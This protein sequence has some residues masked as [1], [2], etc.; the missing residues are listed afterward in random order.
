MQSEWLDIR[1]VKFCRRWLWVVGFICAAGAM[2]RGGGP[3][4]IVNG[5]AARWPATVP[6]GLVLDNGPLG[7]LSS[8]QAA[9]L[10]GRAVDAWNQVPGS[11]ITFRVDGF[12]PGGL[13]VTDQNLPNPRSFPG[14]SP[15]IYD[16][17]GQ[18][19]EM[20]FGEG[21]SRGVGGFAGPTLVDVSSRRVISGRAV[22]NGLFAGQMEIFPRIVIHELGHVLGLGHTQAAMSM[23]ELRL[24]T[25]PIMYPVATAGSPEIPQADDIAWLSWLYPTNAFQ[26]QT[27]T[28]QGRVLRRVDIPFQGANV[29]AVK[30]VP[31]ESNSL[32][33]SESEFVSAV[34]D[35]SGGNTGRFVIP[36]LNPGD[37]VVRIEP[38]RFA[39]GRGGIGPVSN[40]FTDFPEDYFN[41][42]RESG[43]ASD[44]PAER[45]PLAV[46]AG[47]ILPLA[48]LISNDRSGD[49]LDF[50]RDDDSKIYVFPEGFR[51]P[52]GDRVFH[53]VSIN[54]DGNLTLGATDSASTPRNSSRFLGG[55]SRIAP[56]FADLDPSR[57]GHITA[58]AETG[59]VTFTWSGVPRF[60]G[61]AEECNTF[62]VTL[63]ENG[64]ILFRYD[65]ISAPAQGGLSGGLVGIRLPGAA[66]HKEV[67]FSATSAPLPIDGPSLLQVFQND[68]A[69]L[70]GRQIFFEAA[71]SRRFF[72]LHQST[73]DF[74]TSFAFSN[75]EQVD[76]PL[77]LTSFDANGGPLPLPDNPHSATLAAGQQLARLAR[78]SFQAPPG[79]VQ[80]GW[81]EVE[82]SIPTVGG[83]FLVGDG[84]RGSVTLLDGAVVQSGVSKLLYFT[85]VYQG[86]GSFSTVPDQVSGIDAETVLSLANP[87]PEP[88]EIQMILFDAGGKAVNAEPVR[89]EIAG[90]GFF[91]DTVSRLFATGSQVLSNGFVRVDVIRGEGAAG[92][93][94]IRLPEAWLVLNAFG[95]NAGTKLFSAQLGNGSDGT[96]R[97]FTNLKL[98]NVSDGDRHVL[99][100]LAPAPSQT[101]AQEFRS[102]TLRPNESFQMN[103]AQIFGLGSPMTAPL[104]DG[105]LVVEADG[106]GIIGD[107]VFG[108]PAAATFAA[109][110]ALQSRP[111]QKALFSHVANGPAAADQPEE[112]IFTGLA[113]FNPQGREAVF[114][115]SVFDREG[116]LV[117]KTERL[118]L[119]P[120]QRLQHLVSDLAPASENLMGGYIVLESDL[121]IV[122]QELFGN[123][124]LTYLSAVPPTI[125][126]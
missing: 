45:V 22:L 5:L 76:S 18:I 101:G 56:L 92:L 48:D 103:A 40:P 74:F 118:T 72:P 55:P 73:A 23:T 83:F 8:D 126:E 9:D 27:G 119:L 30:V 66:D 117:A 99:L 68:L 84:L 112:R 122:G 121:P 20:I 87:N 81:I 38:L 113:L 91:R 70:Q 110:L 41:G 35:F 16:S 79:S 109:A 89:Q 71:A 82:T 86:P 14:R 64:N 58:Q 28:I 88:I 34:S 50:F 37:W 125:I 32:R 111:F 105:S 52:F 62:S 36:G 31:E 65:Q 11:L 46:E 54:S 21:A 15:V 51:F 61:T 80:N 33:L 17:D 78:E 59:A 120:G 12:L 85:R 13:D 53:G 26:R 115:V 95:G 1:N 4:L 6:V 100:R 104:T 96:N 60:S 39:G 102:V 124:A 7:V 42:D 106:Q 69:N 29:V 2:A 107:V 57:A 25:L 44:D 123:L 93:Q 114:Q 67:D 94:L 49:S 98:V 77:R 43:D 3:V 10:V 47:K 19:T 75:P 116:A 90:R 24:E 97:V 108:D 63:F